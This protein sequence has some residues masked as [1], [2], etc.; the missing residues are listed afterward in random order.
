MNIKTMNFIDRM[1]KNRAEKSLHPRHIMNISLFLSVI[2]I[3]STFANNN[4]YSQVEISLD[5]EHQP[6]IS[7][8]DNIESQT[9]L[10]FI[11]GSEIYD[12]EKEVSLSVTNAKIDEIIKLLFENELS[13]TLTENVVLLSKA[14]QT[15]NTPPTDDKE[16]LEEIVQILI[17]G[18]VTD[19]N[20][21]PLPG[22]S[23]IEVGTTN[24][25]TTDF[26]GNF[27]LAVDNENAILEVS[28]IGFTT[29]KVAANADLKVVLA[30]DVAGLNEVVLTG[31]GS[32][33]KRDIT[34][35]ISVLDLDG[36]A[37]KAN[38]DVGQLLQS[39]SAGVRVVQNNGE[40]GG[41]P[42]IFV[43][44]ISSLSGNTQPLYVID[45]V[46]T[47]STAA[48]DPNNIEDITVL[49]DASAAGIYGAAGA[50]NG[51][52]L[53][54]TKKGRT[55]E[56]KA[57]VNTYV[58]FSEL[59]RKIPL[60]G[61]SDLADY[62]ED[63]DIT[64]TGDDL[65]VYNDWQD[66]TYQQASQTGVNAS[67]SGGGENG[68]FFVGLG[69]L[70][71]E[72]IVVTSQNKRYSLSINLD[73]Q[74]NDW[75]S[76][77]TH[78]NY[79][80][81]NVKVVPDDMGARYGG[82]ISSAL[83]TPPFQ[84]IF[85]DDGFYTIAAKNNT[86]MENP[87]SYIYGN[88]N[89]NIITN[90]VADA[91]FSIKL[92]YN[93]TFKTQM[94]VI[95]RSNRYSAF[96]DPTLVLPAKDV[97]GEVRYNTG[98]SDRFI[99]DNTL[100]YDEIFGNHKLNVVIGSST[101][102]ENIL[103]SNQT[104]QNL[105]SET[106]RTLNT[107]ATTVLNETTQ[108]S[109]SLQSY[110]ARANYTYD[111][112]YSVTASVR[113]DG[114]SRISSDNRWASFKTFSMGWNLSNESF[115]QDVDVVKNLKLRAGYGETGNLPR[116]LNSYANIVI[117]DEVAGGPNELMPG[118][119]PDNQA[120]NF[121]LQWETSEQVNI[122]LDFSILDDRI[123]VTTDYYTKKTKNMIFPY[124]LPTSTG[125]VNKIVNL[126]GYIENKGFEFAV[127][128]SLINKGDFSWNTLY[129]MSFNSNVVKD[130]PN[131]ASIRS[132][133]LQNLGGNLTMTK[134]GLP[135][136]SFWGYNS[137]GV[138]PQTGDLIFTDNDGV[139]GITPADKQVIGNPMPDFTYGF[140]NEF[141]YKNWDLNVVIDGVSGNDIYNTGKQN[142]QAMRL[143]ENQSA[144]IVR[145]WKNPGDITDIPRAT[146]T[147][148]NGNSDINSRWVED[149]SYLRVRDIS[150]S[151][152]FDQDVLDAINISGLRLYANLKNW[153]T[154]TDY[155]GYSPEV[156]RNIND[157]SVALTQGVDYGSFPQAKSFSVGLNIEF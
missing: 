101:S 113:T 11:F 96:K 78:L 112:K 132:T 126:D 92:P 129:N 16:E 62:F 55:G 83:Q 40:P 125:F 37:E 81:A 50:S 121:D 107:A 61:S 141:G 12:F 144:D 33:N 22:A 146:A 151:Y 66:L 5:V 145:R 135:L 34:S 8:L 123:Y 27:K 134:N 108:G 63:I 142:L 54:T 32:Q 71:Q 25:T 42:Q 102:E 68:S 4:V 133:L 87:L 51:V 115:M 120:G 89:N 75:L 47:Y 94:G 138:D 131:N 64:L 35:S 149:G 15:S 139:D 156:N 9:E 128:A 1:L 154:I 65:S 72:G 31:Y 3:F 98:E 29:Q 153:F 105:A 73:Q 60:L 7:I 14:I 122:G 88:D 157:E 136:A 155:S 45:G 127:N 103:T 106:R 77:G 24:G 41:T 69:Y 38:T 49:K 130:I 48:L 117:V 76:F 111:D 119:R 150:L 85:D 143:P 137:E 53:I 10:R 56:F 84:P 104:K 97:M 57:S 70:D 28:F 59:I 26:D 100:S 140:I 82:A 2:M 23:V 80:R 109:W 99:F 148:T 46:V 18:N 74:I 21:N 67:I 30:L 116:G 110:F 20:G 19:S 124:P 58:G 91:N 43:R 79:T 17:N 90:M 36:T 114:S 118:R 93:L 152:N 39:R 6:I 52:V 13:Y 147:D 86:G 95:L 44:G